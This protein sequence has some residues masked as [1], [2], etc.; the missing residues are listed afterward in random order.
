M[1]RFL[2]AL[3]AILGLQSVAHANNT[4]C[5]GVKVYYRFLQQDSGIMRMPA[6]WSIF[7]NLD[8]GKELNYSVSANAMPKYD[9]EFSEKNVVSG[10]AVS[11]PN[12]DETYTAKLTVKTQR[13][14]ELVSDEVTCR[15]TQRF[16]P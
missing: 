4:V 7:A 13:G 2:F 11:G 9:I 5:A 10:G 15:H 3:V 14:K 6:S 1:T 16:L 12:I 8:S